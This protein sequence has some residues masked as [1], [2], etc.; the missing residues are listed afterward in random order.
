MQRFRH[1]LAPDEIFLPTLIWNSPFRNC[2]FDAHDAG[3][4]SQRL[5]DWERGHP[6]TWQDKDFDE[7]MRSSLLFA[8]KFSAASPELLRQLRKALRQ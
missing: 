7:L 8:R 1:T 5:V 2:L 6:Y 3:R 4:G